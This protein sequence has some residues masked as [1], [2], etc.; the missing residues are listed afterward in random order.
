LKVRRHLPVPARSRK[1]VFMIRSAFLVPI[2]IL[3]LLPSCL[4]GQ[5]L[6][7]TGPFVIESSSA[8]DVKALALDK[9]FAVAWRRPNSTAPGGEEP[10][11]LHARLLSAKGR[12][13]ARLEPDTAQLEFGPRD[14][15]SLVRDDAGEISFVWSG[16]STEDGS[17]GLWLQRFS[18]T[19]EPES[20]ERRKLGDWSLGI[21]HSA[22]AAGGGILVVAWIEPSSAANTAALKTRVFA[23]D[24]APLTESMTM[25]DDELL[26][27]T[28][29]AAGVDSKGRFVL[30]WWKLEQH[31]GHFYTCSIYGQRFAPDGI[32]LGK[33]F[34]FGTSTVYKHCPSQYL[35]M[36]MAADGGFAVAHTF[37]DNYTRVERFQP[38]DTMVGGGGWLVYRSSLAGDRYGN[39][40]FL[41]G[42]ILLF[43]SHAIRQDWSTGHTPMSSLALNGGVLAAWEESNSVMGKLWKVRHE[44]DACIYRDNR[45]LCDTAGDGGSPD[46]AISFGLDSA[47][48][49]PLMGDFDGDGRDDPCLYL[50]GRFFCDTA[51]DGGLP[52]RQTRYLGQPGD[53]P[54]L[55]DLDGD[56]RDDPC[57][58]RGGFFLCDSNRDGAFDPPI[59]FGVPGDLA[60]IGDVNGDR[61]D[62]P[63]VVRKGWFLC[64]TAH[65][66]GVAEARLSLVSALAGLPQGTPALGDV[67]GDGRDDPCV[68]TE[69]RLL[70]GLFP[71]GARIPASVLERT[72][73][74]PGDAFLMGN[75]DA[76]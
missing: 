28:S 10:G 20:P 69:G 51:Q 55:G 36:T 45:F 17:A 23:P 46:V 76:F 74:E 13:G 65:N 44:A 49:I 58:R 61:R 38:D 15:F 67:D 7:Q 62:D 4:L 50:D 26:L 29:I 9:G 71:K 33:R 48:R 66:G 14:F 22:A 6:G 39:F 68:F 27:N 8:T 52:E 3:L 24:G 34:S 19:G 1:E 21:L 40:V 16:K 37:A 47:A 54:L 63:C 57:V 70:C 30:L 43:N 32:P 11:F 75:L 2:F 41:L 53:Q 64:D 35:E 25:D 56:G 5:V 59:A 72:F 73:G 42:G 18:S 31:P 60:L 12:P